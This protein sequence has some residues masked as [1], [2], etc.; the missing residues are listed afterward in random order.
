[1][2]L[3]AISRPSLAE[4]DV[5][6]A[7]QLQLLQAQRGTRAAA[8]AL[9][10]CEHAASVQRVHKCKRTGLRSPCMQSLTVMIDPAKCVFTGTEHLLIATAAPAE[11]MGCSV[12]PMGCLPSKAYKLD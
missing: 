4:V 10:I 11:S 8:S 7:G 3:F 6:W 5:M 9:I 12:G 2:E 1:V